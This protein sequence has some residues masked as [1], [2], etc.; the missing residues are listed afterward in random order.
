[1]DDRGDE[2]G[3]WGSR[4]AVARAGGLFIESPET[5]HPHIAGC[6]SDSQRVVI[7][8]RKNDR[9]SLLL[10]NA[11]QPSEITIIYARDNDKICPR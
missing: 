6:E 1:V 5:M 9:L 3:E 4:T 11:S 8:A 10:R 2:G 7:S